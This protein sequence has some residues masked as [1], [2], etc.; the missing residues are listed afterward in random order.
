MVARGQK[1]TIWPWRLYNWWS[2]P[3]PSWSPPPEAG[4]GPTSSPVAGKTCPKKQTVARGQ[5]KKFWT[6]GFGNKLRLFRSRWSP[7][8]TSQRAPSSAGAENCVR[9]TRWWP[10]VRKKNFDHG[11][12]TT[13][14]ARGLWL[15]PG[16][17]QRGLD[18]GEAPFVGKSNLLYSRRSKPIGICILQW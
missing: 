7:P 1:K 18:S 17:L 4:Q 15:A 12:Y 5:R 16:R 2:R 10:A 3:E 14:R 8:E 11:D 6:L 9:K 13:D